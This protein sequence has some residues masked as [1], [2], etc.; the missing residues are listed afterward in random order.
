MKTL[1]L[2]VLVIMA[3]AA[4]RTAL[5]HPHGAQYDADNLMVIAGTV[6]RFDLSSDPNWLY[7]AVPSDD[8]SARTWLLEPNLPDDLPSTP[9]EEMDW[10]PGDTIIA[11]VA[12]LRDGRP[13]GS[14]EAAIKNGLERFGDVDG[15]DA[16]P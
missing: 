12:P 15:L 13:A 3:A 4:S 10:K 2:T 5:A 1:G 9:V 8:G 6:Q 16:A 11:R 7:V 14:M